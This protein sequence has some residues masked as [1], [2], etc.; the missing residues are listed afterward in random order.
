[1]LFFIIMHE[2]GKFMAVSF[3]SDT[4]K[5]LRMA[6]NFTQDY[7]AAALG[8]TRQTYSH[9][10]TGKRKPST[11]TIYKLSILYHIS[12]NDLLHLSFPLDSNVFYEAPSEQTNDNLSDYLDYFNTPG[13]KKKFKY[14]TNLEKELL[15][16]FEKVDDTDKK[17]LVEI[18][19]IKAKKTA[20]G[21]K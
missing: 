12:A 21:K 6:N 3:L 1:M 19:K 8:I 20:S 7:V 16:Y 18:A 13:N 14:N 9:Y 4:L 10:E 15:Y 11:E 5:Q 17:E 2:E